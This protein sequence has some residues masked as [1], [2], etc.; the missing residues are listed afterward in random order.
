MAGTFLKR[1]E[2]KPAESLLPSIRREGRELHSPIDAIGRSA[3]HM[4]IPA[5]QTRSGNGKAVAR[6]DFDMRVARNVSVL[7]MDGS[8]PL[9]ERFIRMLDAIRAQG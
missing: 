2:K 5:E 9:P 7:R 8:T 1:E 3:A 4:R 6:A